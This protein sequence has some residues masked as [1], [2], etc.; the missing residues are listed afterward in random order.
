MD[1]E[2][3]QLKTHSEESI[4]I[5][6]MKSGASTIWM[7]SETSQLLELGETIIKMQYMYQ[8]TLVFHC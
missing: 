5:F 2:E 8:S 3:I 1:Q 6:P 4:S 7:R